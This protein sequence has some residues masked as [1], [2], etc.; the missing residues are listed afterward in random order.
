MIAVYGVITFLVFGSADLQPWAVPPEKDV[1][2]R[3]NAAATLEG[4]ADS[5]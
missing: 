1:K 4:R 3:E 5:I 2:S